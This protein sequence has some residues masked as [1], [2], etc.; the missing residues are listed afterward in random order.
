MAEP[1]WLVACRHNNVPMLQCA[2]TPK[3]INEE[4]E[5]SASR[6]VYTPLIAAVV[7]CSTECVEWLI[8]H[9]R[10]HIN[11][12]RPDGFTPLHETVR[13][14]LN[15]KPGHMR[16]IKLLLEGGACAQPKYYPTTPLMMLLYGRNDWYYPS[17]NHV[18]EPI[19]L[20]IDAGA[21]LRGVTGI[22]VM[23]WVRE[24]IAAREQRRTAAIVLMGI[25]AYGRAMHGL[26]RYVVQTIAR[27]VWKTI[28]E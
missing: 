17:S 1:I 28:K 3:N 10:I 23:D 26:D 27:H 19:R 12:E 5:N 14:Y 22:H 15:G 2:I 25:R 4:Y 11:R 8:N 21:H 9:P 6:I 24:R 13:L 18:D 16:I 20:L 7:Y